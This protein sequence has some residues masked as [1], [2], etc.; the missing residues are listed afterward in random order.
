MRTRPHDVDLLLDTVGLT[1][2]A[3]RKIST[4]V[5]WTT[6]GRQ[7]ESGHGEA[8]ARSFKEVTR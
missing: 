1:E 8:A 5:R 3:D 4:L 7:H 2:L 6:D